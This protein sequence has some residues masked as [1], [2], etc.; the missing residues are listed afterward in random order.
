DLDAIQ[1]N[2]DHQI[3]RGLVAGKGTLLSA[4]AG[5]DFP[6][7]NTDER[8]AVMRAVCQAAQGRAVVIGCAQ[9][10]STREAVMLAQY[11]QDAG[12]HAVQLSPPWY[13]AP[14]PQQVYSFFQAAATSVDI[15][16]MVYHTPWL[17]CTM[18]VDL[19]GQLAED[20]PNIRALK[21][22]GV[23][24]FQ[25]V[26]AY[27]RL[28]PRMAIIDNAWQP[29]Q[30]FLLGAA[31]YVSHLANVW[32]EHEVRFW[33]MLERGDLAGAVREYT[34]VYWRWVTLRV[35]AGEHISSGE[36]FL[37]KRAAEMTGFIGGPDR[38]PMHTLGEDECRHVRDVLRRMGAPLIE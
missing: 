15:P 36:S 10:P 23:N 8:K 6:L 21:W 32:P 19:I 12:C 34:E 18:E 9:S 33:E 5:G 20:F 38:G 29:V 37:V 30:S 25:H 31:G 26:D 16:I 28:A 7:L 11:A 27:V 2:G 4:G 3:R 24:E 1:S 22:V 13:Y 17:G 14:L 35:W